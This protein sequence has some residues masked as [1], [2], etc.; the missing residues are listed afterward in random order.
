MVRVNQRLW[1]IPGQRTKRKAWGFT[2]RINGKQVRRSK[3]ERTREDAEAE[4]AKT[5]LQIE[6][7]K[8]KSPGITL[9]Q[10]A[11]RYLASKARKRTIEADRRQLE[12]LKVEFGADTPLVEITA[13]RISEYKAK[14]LA[15]V[16][17]IGEGEVHRTPANVCRRQ[18]PTRVTP[19][20]PP[21]GSRRVGEHRPR[22][23]DPA[24]AGAPRS[25]A[26]AD[27]G[28]DHAPLPGGQQVEKQG[29]SRCGDRRTEHRP[30]AR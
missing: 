15:A 2:A 8:P 11:E 19:P 17:K 16:R 10:A 18:P 23:P 1:R 6:P 20:S 25:A 26:M 7:Q 29:A 9:A 4:L 22:T 30:A 12:M 27:P 14:R 21:A 5:L 24:R 3:T 28:G 13:S